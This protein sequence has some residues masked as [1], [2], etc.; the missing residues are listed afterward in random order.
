MRS[1]APNI[2]PKSQISKKETLKIKLCYFPGTKHDL[3]EKSLIYDD[4]SDVGQS[5]SRS[6][7]SDPRSILLP[8]HEGWVGGR[9]PGDSVYDIKYSSS[10]FKGLYQSN[11]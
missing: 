1:H 5:D 7:P 6:S 10:V 9:D 2:G 11:V 4:P 3:M 8:F